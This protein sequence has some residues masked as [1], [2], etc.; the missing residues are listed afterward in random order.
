MP[1]SAEQG[2]EEIVGDQTS[3]R[4]AGWVQGLLLASATC[5][6]VLSVS[7]TLPIIPAMR[8]AFAGQTG[9]DMLVPF[10]VV[11]PMLTVALSGPFAGALGDRIGRRRL[12]NISTFVFAVF[13]VLPFWL[14]DFTL[15][16]ASRAVT[17]IALGGMLTSAVGLTG[18]YFSGAARQRWLAIQ[19][20]AG[21]ITAVIAASVSGALAE[22]NWRLPFLMLATAFPLF[23]ALVFFR[24]PATTIARNEAAQEVAREARP[25]AWKALGAIFALAVVASFTLWPPAYA[26]GVLLEEKS[27]GS[28]MLT[29]FTT[30]VLA[31]GAVVGA[32]SIALMRQLTLPARQAVAFAMGG[33]GTLAIWQATS[34]PL[35]IVGAFIVGTGEGMTGPILSDWLLEETPL[36]LRGR[37][38]GFF[39]TIFF[40]AQF[41]SPLLAQ[42]VARSVGST[43]L[44]MLC[45]AIACG[46]P[47][48]TIM[49]FRLSRR[50]RVVSAA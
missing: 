40:L 49:A 41:A 31:G 5:M 7:A 32:A 27:L 46:L 21:A 9:I 42:A 6:L 13:A 2:W 34:L 8:H 35:L 38:V 3:E 1:T 37:T 50:G 10:S 14:S 15:V 29:G 19:G 24:G 12:L 16:V 30:S 28:S 23:A 48:M 22:I 44:S 47:L 33:I 17:G 4:H 25:V 20:G 43:T 26:F 11:A 39:Q 36:R 18:D 45:Y